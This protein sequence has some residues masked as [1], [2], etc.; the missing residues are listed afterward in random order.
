MLQSLLPSQKQLELTVHSLRDSPVAT[1]RR[2]LLYIVA[3]RDSSRGG[4]LTADSACDVTAG[5]ER[6]LL[7]PG[8]AWPVS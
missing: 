5:R 1:P 8:P 3:T 4:Y 6:S 7:A 2:C